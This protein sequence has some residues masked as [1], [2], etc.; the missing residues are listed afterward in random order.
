[1]EPAHPFGDAFVGP[2][3]DPRLNERAIKAEID[4]RHARHC[5]KFPVI[6][7][8]VAAQCADIIESARFKTNEI[9]PADQVGGRIVRVLGCHHRLVETR[10]QRIDEIDVAGELVVLLLRDRTG[11]EDTEMPDQLVNRIDDRLAVRSY[12]IDTLVEV[13][14]PLQRLWR[15]RDIVRLR[16]EDDDRGADVAQIDAGAVRRHDLC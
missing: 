1:M 8:V 2:H 13:E 11:H 12:V 7:F 10:R 6:L 16:T 5:R 4:L 9:V 14:N 15:R 3:A